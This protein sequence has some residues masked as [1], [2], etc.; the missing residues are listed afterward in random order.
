M[1][2]RLR[3]LSGFETE[4]EGCVCVIRKVLRRGGRGGTSDQ[5]LGSLERIGGP[6]GY[7]DDLLMRPGECGNGEAPYSEQRKIN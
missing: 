1:W 2:E 7:R 4:L 3:E 6:V 5:I